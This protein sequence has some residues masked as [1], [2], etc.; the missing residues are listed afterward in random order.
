MPQIPH[1]SPEYKEHVSE[2]L[3]AGLAA[4]VAR[5]EAHM[6]AEGFAGWDPYDALKSP[7]FR[8]PVLRGSRVARFGAQQV[9]RRLPVN[10]RPM[11][12]IAKGVNPVTLGLALEGYAALGEDRRD[13]ARSLVERLGGLATPGFSGACW[14]YDFPW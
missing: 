9:L 14:G 3:L 8:L 1:M 12:G 11:L 2:P 6:R 5:T 13:D 7:L 4:A 10:L